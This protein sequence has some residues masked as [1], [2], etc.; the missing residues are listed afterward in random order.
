MHLKASLTSR[1][2]R[3][4]WLEKNPVKCPHKYAGRSYRTEWYTNLGDQR[5]SSNLGGR[6]DVFERPI[7][8]WWSI[9]DQVLSS[10]GV[11]S[12]FPRKL[13][14]AYDSPWPRCQRGKCL[15]IE[16]KQV[17]GDRQIK[18]AQLADL[19]AAA[20][21]Q[22]AVVHAKTGGVWLWKRGLQAGPPDSLGQGR[23]H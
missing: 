14:R 18:L 2:Y 11:T 15:P 21:L 16:E 17:R 8:Q 7:H 5:R 1:R 12:P 6:L 22:P 23:P 3:T 4:W 10:D 13:S 20:G 19:Q 9:H